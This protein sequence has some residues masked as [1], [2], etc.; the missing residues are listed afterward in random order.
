TLLR[1][2]PDAVPTLTGTITF[3]HCVAGAAAG[4]PTAGTATPI[5]ASATATARVSLPFLRM[6]LP[7]DDWMTKKCAQESP[8]SRP[9]WDG[10]HIRRPARR[11]RSPAPPTGR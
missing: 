2:G 10:C 7:R 6:L 8:S 5:A 3:L 1:V 11:E 9:R 4:S